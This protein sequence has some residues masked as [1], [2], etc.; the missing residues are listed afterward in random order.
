MSSLRRVVPSTVRM[1]TADDIHPRAPRW[2]ELVP[3]ELWIMSITILSVD[4][5]PPRMRTLIYFSSQYLTSLGDP[6]CKAQAIRSSQCDLVGIKF[7]VS[8][9]ACEKI[10]ADSDWPR[11]GFK[12]DP[13]L[14]IRTLFSISDTGAN[15]FFCG[16]CW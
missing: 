15:R 2:T 6:S 14:P 11:A 12:E 4:S 1:E 8:S 7:K 10:R 3:I 16:K 9:S 5:C 13:R